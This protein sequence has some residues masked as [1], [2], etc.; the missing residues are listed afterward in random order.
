MFTLQMNMYIYVYIYRHTTVKERLIIIES[1]LP[2]TGAW[3]TD[4]TE[5]FW[6]KM[7]K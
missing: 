2:S 3:S 7:E 5:G 1:L 4:N 6:S